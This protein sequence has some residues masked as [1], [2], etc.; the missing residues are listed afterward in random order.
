MSRKKQLFSK[1]AGTKT[2]LAVPVLRA[3]ALSE[4]KLA[5]ELVASA[6]LPTLTAACPGEVG[7]QERR[8]GATA[9]AAEL[10]PAR[11]AYLKYY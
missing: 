2:I 1:L 8:R 11:P 9:N 5:H 3:F 7:G 10:R 6:S 4:V